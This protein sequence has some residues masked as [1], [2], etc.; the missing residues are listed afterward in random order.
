RAA[1]VLALSSQPV[2]VRASAAASEGSRGVRLAIVDADFRG[3]EE[4]L[5][6]RF[7]GRVEYIDLAAE[8]NRDLLPKTQAGEIASAGHGTQCALAAVLAAP[9]ARFV[10]V[11]IDADAP[12][13]LLEVARYLNGEAVRSDNLTR[14][15]A[16]L[17]ADRE[18]LERRRDALLT[19]RR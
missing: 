10:L 2:G 14:R 11:R 12:Y 9:D 6:R 8:C 18:Q 1:R 17:A 7:P 13:Q 4:L 15:S 3:Y 19:E 5:A 16:E